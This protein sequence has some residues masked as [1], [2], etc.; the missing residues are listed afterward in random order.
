ML[1]DSKRLQGD[2][3]R[4]RSVSR[5]IPVD[6]RLFIDSID[7]CKTVGAWNC[8]KGNE[9]DCDRENEESRLLERL[10]NLGITPNDDE[11]MG[12]ISRESE[13]LQ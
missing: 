10:R 8:N 6:G 13:E 2:F 4:R 1:E 3:Y 11:C 5:H 12:V 9:L 7:I